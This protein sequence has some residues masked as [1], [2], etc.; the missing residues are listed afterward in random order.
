MNLDTFLNHF[1]LASQ[2]FARAVPEAGLVRHRSFAEALVRLS[3]AVDTQTPALLTAEPGLGKSTLLGVFA[4][5]IDRSKTRL[6]YTALSSCG[7][8]GLV[9]QLA[10]RYGVNIRRSAAQTA[11]AILDELSR[12][13]RTE[14]LILDEAHRLP[15]TSLDELRLLNNLDF[16]RTP[17]F[18]LLLVGQSALRERLAEARHA[19]LAQRLAIRASLGPLSES[20]SADYLDRRLR[21]AGARATLFRPAA[22]GRVFEKTGGVPRLIN[23]LATASLLAAASRGRKHIELQD[24]DDAAFDQENN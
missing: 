19:S 7:P 10:T 20:E 1:G 18:A 16:D 2:P 21:A 4:D 3:L 8:F 14:I 5:S 13:E 23:N 12:S 17:P 15:D 11:L 22:A 9:G 6:V 24:V